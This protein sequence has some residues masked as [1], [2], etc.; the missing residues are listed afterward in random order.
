MTADLVRGLLILVAVAANGMA[1]VLNFRDRD[2][3]ERAA[4]VRPQPLRYTRGAK[5]LTCLAV[6]AALAALPLFFV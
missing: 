6:V 5:L 4:R 3:R 2:R 1:I